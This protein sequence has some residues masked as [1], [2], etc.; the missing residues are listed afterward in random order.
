MRHCLKLFI[1]LVFISI[2]S[3]SEIERNLLPEKYQVKAEKDVLI[4]LVGYDVKV[5][6]VST[7]ID[8]NDLKK[9]PKNEFGYG[10]CKECKLT[11]WISFKDLQNDKVKE[12]G[13]R[14]NKSNDV[15]KN[16]IIIDLVNKA[17][18]K[19]KNLLYAGYYAVNG[20]NRVTKEM[21][22]Y[23]YLFDIEQNKIYEFHLSF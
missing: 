16:E 7:E 13:N 1:V 4:D 10:Y 23:F 21:Y 18:L 20:N 3:C 22:E 17:E 9:Y 14:L 5:F 8:L 2:S 12:I 19:S 15:Y 11:T 6:S